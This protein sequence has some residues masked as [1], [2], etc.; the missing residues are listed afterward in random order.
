MN[1]FRT[2]ELSDPQFESAG[3]RYITIKTPNLNGR[4]DVC[5]FVPEGVADETGLPVV[6]LLHGVYGSAWI[7]SQ[8]GGA[9]VTAA[10][11]IKEGQIQPMILA[12]PSDGLWGDGSAYLP[13]NQYNFEQWIVHDVIQAVV[14][15]IPQASA[16]SN[17]FISG[18]SMGGFGALR[19]GSKY[20]QRFRGIS[21]HSSI[22]SLPQMALFVEESLA[23]YA[24]AEKYNED[25]LETMLQYKDSLPPIRF[26]CGI[27]DELIE[28]NRTL[29]QQMLE[30]GIPHQ[31]EE[32]EGGHQW[33]YW[34]EHVK[35]SL[36][37]FHQLLNP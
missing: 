22:T 16:Q 24:Q 20:G 37:F 5:V 4:G 29:H 1:S 32:F 13:H 18:L 21:A 31:Y 7:W 36:R 14:E 12:M 9:H 26:D 35:D 25:V 2:I 27:T 15:N 34:V 19:L 10:Q 23:N 8:K 6:V 33:P 11:L 30:H 28:Y 17:V 3:L